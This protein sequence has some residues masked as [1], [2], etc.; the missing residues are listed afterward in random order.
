MLLNFPLNIPMNY[1]LMLFSCSLSFINYLRSKVLRQALTVQSFRLTDWKIWSVSLYCR[2][3]FGWLPTFSTKNHVSPFFSLWH[4]RVFYLSSP[5]RDFI[6]FS[7]D[8][9]W[10]WKKF[11]NYPSRLHRKQFSFRF[12]HCQWIDTREMCFQF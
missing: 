10:K 11:F 1:P 5:A 6:I 4:Q 9:F 12:Q 2:T 3:F 7:S 8:W